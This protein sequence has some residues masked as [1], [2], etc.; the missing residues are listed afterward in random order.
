MLHADEQ[1]KYNRDEGTRDGEKR[2]TDGQSLKSERA[3]TS[4]A[5]KDRVVGQGVKQEWR[6]E[7]F[8]AR[9]GSSDN[10][11]HPSLA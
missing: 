5:V 7:F 4:G 9:L 3:I 10:R 1:R 8:P 11:Q 2:V 6:T